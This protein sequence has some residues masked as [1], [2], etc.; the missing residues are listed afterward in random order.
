V[1][2]SGRTGFVEQG[3]PVAGGLPASPPLAGQLLDRAHLTAA[4]APAGFLPRHFLHLE[5][6]TGTGRQ[7]RTGWRPRTGPRK[8]GAPAAEASARKK[9]R[10]RATLAGWGGRCRESERRSHWKQAPCTRTVHK[11]AKKKRKRNQRK[12]ASKNVQKSIKK[13][14]NAKLG[15]PSCST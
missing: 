2:E 6:T 11:H 1:E 7:Q 14:H 9:L 12:V 3:S 4:A 13:R 10:R 15:A 8:P 5:A